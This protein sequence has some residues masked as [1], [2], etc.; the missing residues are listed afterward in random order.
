M[1]AEFQGMGSAELTVS[2]LGDQDDPFA[3]AR[4]LLEEFDPPAAPRIAVGDRARAETL[5]AIQGLLP[6]ATFLSA[7]EQLRSLRM[8]KSEEEIALLR[9]AGEITEAAFRDALPRLE[10]GMTEWDLVSEIDYQLVRHGALCSSFATSLYC[11]GPGHPLVFGKREETLRRELQ[12]PVAVLTDFG[13]VHEG[14]C[15]D[16]GRTI[17]FGEPD[18][19]FLDVFDRVMASQAA[20]IRALQ[21]GVRTAA[22]ADAEARRIIEEAGLRDCFKHR[23]GHGIGLDVHEPP[24][25]T[26]GD[27]TVLREGMTFTCEPSIVFA[28]RCSARVEDV[29]VVRREGG[30]PLTSGFQALHIVD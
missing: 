26:A 3:F 11:S 20:G 17:F 13:A 21:A 15:Y 2:V 23:L 6:G 30:E 28:D 19:E 12:P 14:Y 5:V 27:E 24:F 25:L 22:G 29:V 1:T 10:H 16:Y 9:R 7:T 8:I 18:A 4:K